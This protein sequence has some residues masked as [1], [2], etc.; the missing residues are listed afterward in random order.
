MTQVRRIDFGYFV[1][2][3]AA[4]RLHDALGIELADISLVA[5]SHPARVVFAH[6]A[7]VW[8]P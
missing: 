5:N 3:A 7:G 4:T 1:R 8:V 6:D 2:P